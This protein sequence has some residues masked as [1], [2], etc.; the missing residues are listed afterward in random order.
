M[1]FNTV[2]I[3]AVAAVF[4]TQAAAESRPYKLPELPIKMSV[5]NVLSGLHRRDNDTS[6]YQPDAVFCGMGTTCSEACGYGFATCPS[7]QNEVHCYNASALQ[8]CCPS[9]TGDSCDHG[10]Y[11]T[12]DT[13]G[14]TFCCPEGS[15]TAECASRFNVTG[16]LTS[17][18]PTTTSS[19]YPSFSSYPAYNKTVGY[20]S[21]ST[22]PCT[23]YTTDVV[24]AVVPTPAG[25]SSGSYSATFSPTAAGSSPSSTTVSQSGASASFQGS[26]G[27]AALFAAAAAFAL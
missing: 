25:S 18:Y 6:A 1:L 23:T 8:T 5:R 14:S 20:N 21:S 7:L 17:Q 11:C 26:M 24:V 10:Y 19:A 3:L 9:G 27:L 2:S 12:S 15:T 16:G 4:A 13:K 22:E